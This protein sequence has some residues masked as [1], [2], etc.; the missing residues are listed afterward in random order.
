[1][2]KK[3]RTPAQVEASRR[4]GAK[5]KGPSSAGGKARSARNSTKHGLRASSEAMIP[6][7]DQH[8]FNLFRVRMHCQI[9]PEG[10]IEEALFEQV[11]FASFQL[12][13]IGP[14]ELFSEVPAEPLG[15]F[16]KMLTYSRYRTSLE[17]TRDKALRQIKEMQTERAL[18]FA[19]YRRRAD[20][21]PALVSTH[22]YRRRLQEY[23]FDHKIDPH[24][25][26]VW[27]RLGPDD[28]QTHA[29]G[30]PRLDNGPQ[31]DAPSTPIAPSGAPQQPLLSPSEPDTK[32]VESAAEKCA[33]EPGE[34]SNS[35]AAITLTPLDYSFRRPAPEPEPKRVIPLSSRTP[36]TRRPTVVPDKKEAA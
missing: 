26:M 9:A 18:R 25:P 13:R 31:P 34:M 24:T 32:T 1:M 6:P 20:E 8:D 36:L 19:P 14:L 5:S 29:P 2:Q 35:R 28:Q 21:I 15:S 30:R 27:P 33:N 17:R 16:G 3:P 7:A 10:P 23:D 4:N 12:N 11:A 22:A